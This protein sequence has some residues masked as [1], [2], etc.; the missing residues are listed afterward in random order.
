M[1][2]RLLVT[3]QAGPEAVAA[4]V[5]MLVDELVAQQASLTARVAVLEAENAALRARLGSDSHNSRKP[6]SSDGPGVKPHPKSQRAVSGRKPGGQPGHAGHSL[7]LVE[8]PDEVQVH[9][10]AHCH[11]CGQNLADVP[12]VR[13]ERRQVV[14]LPPVAAR[15][16]EHQA[17]TTRCPVCGAETTGVFPQ[18]IAAPAQYG[19]GVAAMALYLNQAQLLPLERTCA[20]L[21]EVFGCPVAEATLERAV[22]VCHAQLAETEAAIKRGVEAGL[23]AHFDETGADSGGKLFWFHV[24]STAR[25]TYYAVHQKRGRASPGGDRG[26]GGVSGSGCARWLGELLAVR[27]VRARPV[28]C[29][30]PAGVDLRRGGAQASVGERAEGAAHARSSGR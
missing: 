4:V 23:L 21:A 24:A 11:A 19:P 13:R 1:R 29:P 2:E 8:A 30:S 10:P 20:V 15:V 12:A 9:P 17:E 26:V 28:Q 22:A 14:D 5:G 7:R 25:L 6:P 18:G 3:Y 16:V 27:G